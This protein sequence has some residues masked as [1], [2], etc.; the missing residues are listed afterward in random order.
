[1]PGRTVD[2]PPA[3]DPYRPADRLRVRAGKLGGVLPELQVTRAVATSLRP[4]KTS[5]TVPLQRVQ[6]DASVVTAP[7]PAVA[8]Q[9]FA[10]GQVLQ[11]EQPAVRRRL[12][13]TAE[14]VALPDL[15]RPG[16][17]PPPPPPSAPAGAFLVGLG[18]VPVPLS[19]NPD[20]TYT[21]A[22]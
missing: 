17:P 14:L 10:L 3:P 13:L 6:L 22:P 4:A 5:T 15:V 20:P 2:P 19:P 16:T 7:G 12:V 1:L 8:L 11:L 18:C 21:W 9:H